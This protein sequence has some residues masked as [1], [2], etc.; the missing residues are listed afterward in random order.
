VSALERLREVM[1]SRLARA[2]VLL[3][4]T[5]AVMLLGATPAVA[6]ARWRLSARVAPTQLP[7]TGEAFVT[8]QAID[9]GDA[10]VS[11][12]SVS[13]STPVTI[14]DT[15]PA[16]LTATII[17]Q[18]REVV[19]EAS[20]W[21]CSAPPT[22]V[23]SCTYN[24]SPTTTNGRDRKPLQPYEALEIWINATVENP[25]SPARNKL[26][27][28]GG[29]EQRVEGGQT[30]NGAP[31]PK[32]EEE[33]T[34]AQGPGSTPFGVEQQGY[35]LTPEN[36]SGGAER[37]AGA[38][39]FQLTT[40][41]NLNQVLENTTKNGVTP[42]APALPKNLHF[43][44]PPGLLG[45]VTSLPQC[46]EIAFATINANINGCPAE[47]AVGVARITVFEPE[48]VG[49]VTFTV[50]VFN[51][52]PPP[53]EPAR[54]GLFVAHVPVFLDTHVRT[55]DGQ[56]APGAGDYGVEVSVS[57]IS[58]LA[59]VL[60]SEVTLWGV[61]GDSSHDQSRG[62]DCIA[63]AGQY[64]EVPCTEPASHPTTAFLTLPTSCASPLVTNLTGDSWP[65][66]TGGTSASLTLESAFDLSPFEGCE[67]LPF[68]PAIELSPTTN[69]AST[70]TGL[71]VDVH[72][73]QATTL[74]GASRAESEVR[75][76]TV[77]LP[78][79]IELNPSSANGLEACPEGPEGGVKGIGY[80]GPGSTN[81][82]FSP[83]ATTPEPL[84]FS[85]GVP[86]RLRSPTEPPEC[87]S[88]SKMGTVTVHSPLLKNPL[89]GSV[90]LANPAPL[91][92][93]GRNPFDSLVALYIV[94]EE[95]ES[96]VVVK[97]AGEVKLDPNTGQISSTFQNTPQV[98]FEDFEVHF[99]SGP[100]AS[101]STPAMCGS[102]ASGALFKPWLIT[103]NS[104]Q[105]EAT[106]PQYP[107]VS[108]FQVTSGVGGGGCPS[109]QPFAP[110]F[111][112]GT[113]ELQAGAF[114]PPFSLT[115]SRPDGH[116][117]LTS[118]SVT[119]P[120][121]LAAKISSLTPCPEPQASLGTCGPESLIGEATAVAGYGP[122]PFTVTDGRVYFTGPLPNGAPFGLSIVTPADAGPFH[123]GNVVVQS[124]IHVNPSTAAVTINSALPTIVQGIGR[125]KSGLPLQLKAVHVVVNRPGFQFNP[126]N[127]TP[128]KITGTLGGAGGAVAGVSA[129]FQVK[130]CSSLPFH[131]TF[132]ASTEGRTSKSEGASLKVR[133][134]SGPGQANIG[135]TDLTLPIALPSRL[136]TI[137]KA[138]AEATFNANPASCPEGSNIGSAIVHTPVLK[139]PLSGPAYLVSHGNAAFPD[140]EFIL[141]GENIEL[142]L[143]GKTDIKK[144]ITYSRFETL[145]DAPVSVF[146]TTLPRGPHSALT[147]NVPVSAKY[148]LCG[149][150]LVM[151][152]TITGQNGAVVQQ[153]T[154]I[155]VTG[156]AKPASRAQLLAKALQACRKKFK[157]KKAKK[158]RAACEASARKKYGA[159]KASRSK[160][161]PAQHHK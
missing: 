149:T 9:V 21:T 87:P 139:N 42:A 113:D 3:A 126:T 110:G 119:L 161:K 127:C 134:T 43:N 56:G 132:Q 74:D 89:T 81:D 107:S 114:D 76:T 155:T 145:P 111:T 68:S 51:L 102:Y 140:V 97:I 18:H 34:F 148:S 158:K 15:L 109:S 112:A 60:S 31:M 88:G 14:T 129:P 13:P 85:P 52:V 26:T 146:E 22:K 120:P 1:D 17:H 35:M 75:T 32:E 95:P 65:I 71:N 153:N 128:M 160:G 12:T 152:T 47:T 54:F 156:C 92:E 125:Q 82:P 53:G 124:S 121:G 44:L 136:T 157:S 23:V 7:Q 5:V 41:L 37:Q 49:Y 141:Q 2:T 99:D 48:T 36:E 86:R 138:C 28:E 72:V 104:A 45:N 19:G 147:S 59:Q 93:P 131:P 133:V 94:A 83:S 118:V 16:G 25:T 151:P 101:V 39:P 70:P 154:N 58:Q 143:D 100:R 103:S 79:G 123:L 69:E 55:G 78:P 46:S 117:A 84:R 62:W 108:E 11:S 33:Q 122:N 90:Y 91:G 150:K 4:S 8:V 30:V 27:V 116:Q 77:T 64:E 57:Y 142:V 63:G 10:E 96:E 24:P 66:R 73:P 144:G 38:H 29:L 20:A 98:P 105:I 159:K 135:K 80:Q 6:G 67:G 115:I 61:P 106:E 40:T 137:Q 130:N 50:P